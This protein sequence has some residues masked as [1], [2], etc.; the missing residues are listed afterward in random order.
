LTAQSEE[1]KEVNRFVQNTIQKQDAE[2][3]TDQT[4]SVQE[5]NIFSICQESDIQVNLFGAEP[6]DWTPVSPI[7][8]NTPLRSPSTDDVELDL[9][10]DEMN[11][12]DRVFYEEKIAD[13]EFSLNELSALTIST[14][15][16]LTASQILEEL[17]SSQIE[18]TLEE[19]DFWSEM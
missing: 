10:Q 14:G 8:S 9:A 2:T 18:E 15:D 11:E 3:Q 16:S 6:L 17:K 19:K 1:I 12:S 7:A 13:M 4:L 5:P